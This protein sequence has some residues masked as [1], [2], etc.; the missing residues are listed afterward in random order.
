M[1]LGSNARVTVRWLSWAAISASDAYINM[2]RQLAVRYNAYDSAAKALFDK[3]MQAQETGT[4]VL[5]IP[6]IPTRDQS[7]PA[8]SVKTRLDLSPAQISGYIG[9]LWR[10][11]GGN[12]EVSSKFST[13]ANSG[14]GSKSGPAEGYGKWGEGG[15]RGSRERP[16]QRYYSDSAGWWDQDPHSRGLAVTAITFLVH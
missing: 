4:E 7:W 9:L 2:G 1:E 13:E 14:K 15:G 6:P 8:Q 3:Y 5:R 16:G 10:G 12:G 11:H